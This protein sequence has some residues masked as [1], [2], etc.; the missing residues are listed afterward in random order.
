MKRVVTLRLSDEFKKNGRVLMCWQRQTPD[1]SR[2]E[3]MRDEKMT[4]V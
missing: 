3:P 4:T 1:Y 2:Q